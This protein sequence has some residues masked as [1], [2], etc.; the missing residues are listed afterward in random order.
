MQNRARERFQGLY[1]SKHMLCIVLSILSII[2]YD[3]FL[4]ILLSGS[5]SSMEG[6]LS[7]FWCIKGFEVLPFSE[8]HLGRLMLVSF[9][10]A[11]HHSRGTNPFS[12]D[13][14]MN[15]SM[16]VALCDSPWPSLGVVATGGF[17]FEFTSLGLAKAFRWS[18]LLAVTFPWCFL[19]VDSLLMQHKMM[20]LAFP[21]SFQQM[22]ILLWPAIL[23]LAVQSWGKTG[24][25]FLLPTENCP[26]LSRF[27]FL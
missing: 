24:F 1:V 25:C 22:P 7:S 23:I 19:N 20:L 27:Y 15:A 17:S 26:L 13:C 4:P 21:Q 11:W 9:R 3:P 8:N 18:H 5:F 12:I 6:T 16:A 10:V 2:F 14:V